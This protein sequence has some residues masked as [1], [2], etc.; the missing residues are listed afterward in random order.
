ISLTYQC[1]R[2]DRFWSRR[3]IAHPEGMEAR[4]RKFPYLLRDIRGTLDQ[5]SDSNG[6]DRLTVNLTG[7][8]SGRA[9]WIDGRTD[10]DGLQRR[11]EL[12]IHGDDIPID[13]N[14]IQAMGERR[15]IMESLKASGVGDVDVTFRDRPGD[16]DT[17]IKARIGF[18]KLCICAEAFPYPL[19]NM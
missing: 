9:V 2:G 6:V 16:P 7:T 11:M 13:E 4:H 19:E 8:A 12:R 14:L 1:T 10:G 5:Y 15:P 17:E 3:C 18:R